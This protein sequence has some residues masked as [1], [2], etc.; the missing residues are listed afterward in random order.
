MCSQLGFKRE[1]TVFQTRIEPS[2][3]MNPKRNKRRATKQE[4]IRSNS[5][6]LGK[7]CFRSIRL[8]EK[9]LLKFIEFKCGKTLQIVLQYRTR[10]NRLKLFGNVYR[11]FVTQSVR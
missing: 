7:I 2:K 10:D 11:K 3:N 4:K 1:K 9:H 6:I 5:K 8:Q